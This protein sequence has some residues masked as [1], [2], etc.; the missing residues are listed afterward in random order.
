[1]ALS[2]RSRALGVTQQVW[3]LG[4]PDFPQ[5]VLSKDRTRCNRLASSSLVVKSIAERSDEGDREH[6]IFVNGAGYAR[7]IH[8]NGESA[9]MLLTQSASNI[10]ALN[11]ECTSEILSVDRTTKSSS[12]EIKISGVARLHCA[13]PLTT[14]ILFITPWD[15]IKPVHICHTDLTIEQIVA[16]VVGF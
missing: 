12:H 5:R 6:P 14:G 11:E 13:T 7:A 8:K 2:S 10:S 4:S 16:F 15:L 1:V 3:S 9:L